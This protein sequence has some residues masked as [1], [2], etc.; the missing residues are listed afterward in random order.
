MKRMQRLM[1][2]VAAAVLATAVC[3]SCSKPALEIG[4]DYEGYLMS[5]IQCAVRSDRTEFPV[6]D[7][8]LD[9]YFSLGDINENSWPDYKLYGFA[10]YFLLEENIFSISCQDP[11]DDYKEIE[12]YYFVKE[13]GAEDYDPEEYAMEISFWKGKTFRHHETLTVPEEVFSKEEGVFLFNVASYRYSEE[14]DEVYC[15]KN[16]NVRIQFEKIN[17][18]TVR[19]SRV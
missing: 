19:L 16:G 12:N 10:L 18:D 5:G 7:V 9:C 6:N 1:A 2:A 11:I 17:A 8:T 4:F 3:T 15:G 14:T 13:I